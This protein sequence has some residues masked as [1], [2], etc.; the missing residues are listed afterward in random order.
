MRSH[1]S[2]TTASRTRERIPVVLAP[3]DPGGRIVPRE[4]F[5]LATKGR[6]SDGARPWYRTTESLKR[7]EAPDPGRAVAAGQV[8]IR[9]PPF[10]VRTP[11]TLTNPA[12]GQGFRAF[13]RRLELPPCRAV[14]A[15]GNGTLAPGR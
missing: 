5:A 7:I 4:R 2:T 8:R 1:G 13:V 3:A 10:R 12:G 11:L 9:V 15:G 14:R 6:F